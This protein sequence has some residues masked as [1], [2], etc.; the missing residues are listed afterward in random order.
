MYSFFPHMDIMMTDRT[1]NGPVQD[2]SWILHRTQRL[3]EITTEK[4]VPLSGTEISRT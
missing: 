3:P 2:G 1:Q 4:E